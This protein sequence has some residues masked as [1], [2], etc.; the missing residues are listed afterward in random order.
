[1]PDS[2]PLAPVPTL[3]ARL[4]D[5]TPIE[6][7]SLANAG[8]VLGAA[9]LAWG[10]GTLVPLLG[11]GVGMLGALVLVAWG[12][13][14]PEGRFGA[15]N[16]VTAVRLGGLLLLPVAAEAGPLLLI[17]ASLALLLADGLDGWLARRRDLASEFGAF[18]DKETDALFLLLLCAL[19]A[20]RGRLPDAILLAGLLRYAF[21]PLLFLFPLPSRTEDRFNAARY[22]Y[23][24]MVGAL[25]TS[26][27][28]IPALYQPLVA[29]ASVGLLASFGRSL[30]RI[31]RHRRSLGA[32]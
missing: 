11:G 29:G 16:L 1:M 17:G 23:A 13:W 20:T 12:R 15:A 32:P 7:W 3:T 24:A 21:V 18:F 4:T 10:L 5:A 27:L 30:W 14:S 6:R 2:S 19:A 8:V 9:A 22:A 25:L 28:P 31:V 26:F